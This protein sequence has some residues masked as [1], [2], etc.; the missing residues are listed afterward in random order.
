MDLSY[1]NTQEIFVRAQC[2]T[3]LLYKH[4]AVRGTI[5]WIQLEILDLHLQTSTL[6]DQL[7]LTCVSSILVPTFWFLPHPTVL[8]PVVWE[9]FH[10]I[11]V[12]CYWIRICVFTSYCC[13]LVV[14]LRTQFCTLVDSNYRWSWIMITYH[15]HTT[16]IHTA[17]IKNCGY[18]L[19]HPSFRMFHLLELTTL[20]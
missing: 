10:V 9:D 17:Y 3:I 8:L 1:D 20:I 16:H 11:S 13:E 19:S 7:I 5:N 14:G 2:L 4:F 12:I 18:T 6:G 15:I